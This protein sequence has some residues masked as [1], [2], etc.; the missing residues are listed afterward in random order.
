MVGKLIAQ[1]KTIPHTNTNLAII[2]ANYSIENDNEA[3]EKH[4]VFAW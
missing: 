1:N 4:K 3:P 2:F